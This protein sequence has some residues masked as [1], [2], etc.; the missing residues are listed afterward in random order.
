M[1]L[2][3][4]FRNSVTNQIRLA[5]INIILQGNFNNLMEIVTA[6]GN[7]KQYYSANRINKRD[8]IDKIGEYDI[9]YETKTNKMYPIHTL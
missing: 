3:A 9:T 6:L 5:K 4:R 7:K 1:Q 8:I 2:Y